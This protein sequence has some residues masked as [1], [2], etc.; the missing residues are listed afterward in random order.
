MIFI[1]PSVIKCHTF[2]DPPMKRDVLY[3]NGRRQRKYGN[4]S[5]KVLEN[6]LDRNC[7]L[8]MCRLTF[9]IAEAFIELVNS[10]HNL[11]IP[12]APVKAKSREP[13]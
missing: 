3:Y 1:Y 4:T 10:N 7:S 13:A 5:N 8:V 2:L 9:G 11:E 12:T 6:Y